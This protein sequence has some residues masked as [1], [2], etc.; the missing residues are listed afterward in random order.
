MD[1][2]DYSCQWHRTLSQGQQRLPRISLTQEGVCQAVIS[3]RARAS[4][5]SISRMSWISFHLTAC[6]P[7]VWT[8]SPLSGLHAVSMSRGWRRA[9]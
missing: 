3:K 4:R 5:V 1:V 6:A 2:R 8:N 9:S 7:V